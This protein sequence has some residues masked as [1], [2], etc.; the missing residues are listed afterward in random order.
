MELLKKKEI[1]NLVGENLDNVIGQEVINNIV[2]ATPISETEKLVVTCPDISRLASSTYYQGKVRANF[3]GKDLKTNDG[4]PLRVL[5]TTDRISTGDKFRGNIP[6]KG[7]ILSEISNFMFDLIKGTLP[8]AQLVAEGNVAV[9]ENCDR[10]DFEMVLRQYA[11][12]SGSKTSLYHH[13][14]ILGEREFCGHKLDDLIPNGRLPYLMDTPS[15]KAEKGD[16]DISVPPQFLFDNGL[17]DELVYYN[18]VVR[19]TVD[20]FSK[21]EHF[22]KERGIIFVDTKFEFGMGKDGK[23]KFI[24]EGPSPDASR[25]WELKDY[26]EKLNSGAFERGENPVS[27]SKE[28]TRGLGKGGPLTNEQRYK[29]AC[30]YIETYQLL[31]GRS[32]VP[33]T[34]DLRQK[35][36]EDVNKCLDAVLK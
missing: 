21:V 26:E 12:R 14:F 4:I 33:D 24:D 13:Y 31:L 6:F 16:H 35:T 20:A 1:E 15:T 3:Y 8:N 2:E 36:I 19:G 17:V 10:L 5:V 9:S 27:Y 18:T 23:I 34:R 30:R 11:A 28:L 22:L 29:T 25:F 32:F 7:Q